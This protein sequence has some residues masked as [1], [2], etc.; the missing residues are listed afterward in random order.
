MIA[1]GRDADFVVW[2]PEAEW[3][4]EASRL[5]QRRPLTPYA[6]RRLRGAV[7]S[8]WLRGERI[9]LDPAGVHAARGV[10]LVGSGVRNALPG[11]E[12]KKSTHGDVPDIGR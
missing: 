8:T 10:T 12:S 2:D 11:L 6:G 4:V 7:V 5:R 3:E 1:A 9:D